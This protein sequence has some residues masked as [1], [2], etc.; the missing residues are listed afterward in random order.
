VPWKRRSIVLF[1]VVVALLGPNR[2]TAALPAPQLT[3]VERAALIR[4]ADQPG[5]P[6]WQREVMRSAASA[7]PPAVQSG[8]GA[9]TAYPFIPPAPHIANP[10]SARVTSSAMY[11]PVRNRVI[12]FGGGN[13]VYLN[14]T[15]AL[16]LSPPAWTQIAPAGPSPPPRRGHRAVYDPVRDRMI[17]FAGLDGTYRN[18]T[19]ALTLSGTPTWSQITTA[20]SP[21]GRTDFG[22]V[23][24][25]AG[26]RVV[27]FGGYDG[28][29]TNRR[30]D[31]WALSLA[32][33]PA[34][35]NLTTPGGPTGRSGQRCAYD[36]ARGRM[37]M[38]GG[39]DLDFVNDTWAFDMA[40]NTWSSIAT[41]G[42]APSPRADQEVV[43][44]PLNDGLVVTGGYDLVSNF[45]DTRELRLAGTPT[46]QTLDTGAGSG[47]GPRW[48]AG[49][50]V[51]GSQNVV[52]FGGAAGQPAASGS[53][54]NDLWTLPLAGP[55]VWTAFPP[56][57]VVPPGRTSATAI[58]DPLRRRMIVFGGGGS[59]GFLNDT[60]ALT[61]TN[62]PQWSALTTLGSPPPARRLH[63]AIYDPIRDR[64]LIFG[65]LDDTKFYNDTWALS[66]SGTPTWSP[67]VTTAPPGVRA[68]FASDYDSGN[69]AF[70]L[71]GGSDGVTPRL[72]DSW[73]L[74][75]ATA[76]WTLLPTGPG[77]SARSG[78]RG[79]YDPVNHRL[80]V[81]GGYDGTLLNDTWSLALSGPPVWSPLP[82]LGAPAPRIEAAMTYDTNRNRVMLFGGADAPLSNLFNDVWEL[83]TSGV[84]TW[85]VIAPADSSPVRR[86]GATLIDDPIA[87]RLVMDAGNFR[88][89]SW[90]FTREQP[91]PAEIAAVRAEATPEVVHL[92]WQSP[93]PSVTARLERGTVSNE[94]SD[95]GEVTF[96]GQ[97]RLVVEDREIAPGT[98]Y[99]YRLTIG[100]WHSSSVT[101]RVP[102]GFVLALHP[103][104]S[105]AGL[106]V[107]CVLP[108]AGAFRL[109]VFDVA[110]RRVAGVDEVAEVA[111]SKVVEIPLTRASG[112]LFSRLTQGAQSV[113]RR[114]LVVR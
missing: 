59:G 24:D 77:P 55:T 3:P 79:V 1:L 15:W 26:D 93:T 89:D 66:L 9:W 101:V 25:P 75:L 44:D 22:M 31:T 65:G 98:E 17:V 106:R 30:G 18:D 36:S 57:P 8:T 69:D 45:S 53:L 91:V 20:I 16:T 4:A 84:P 82:T 62:S 108:R 13:S 11:D 110:G 19:W 97:G 113:S 80:V 29:P 48:G 10:P 64:M 87:D 40:T 85:S 70:V 104:I 47:P 35:T 96:D 42:S 7:S 90:A 67:V 41:A 76:T 60:W 72:G 81:F 102:S 51:D 109:D 86:W 56:P 50:V 63:A 61:L 5:L 74:S 73:S 12:V 105:A 32:G 111:G 27:A 107:E 83:S 2:G 78:H 54:Q 14:D 21:P 33:V 88:K 34:W 92:E 23:Y 28:F 49:V 103:A 39:Y 38:F 99:S 71:F 112:L 100:T 43:Y 6:A 68:D 114:A 95:R 58:Y 37:L 94:W 46:W 52:L